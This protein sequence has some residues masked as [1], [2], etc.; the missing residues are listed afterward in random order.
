MLTCSDV[1]LV[2]DGTEI[3]AHRCILTARSAYFKAMFSSGMKESQEG[4][5]H[6]DAVDLVVFCQ[7]LKFMYTGSCDLDIKTENKDGKESKSKDTE[8][9]LAAQL[10]AAADRFQLT[11]LA[12]LCSDRLGETI[13]TSNALDLLVI[14]DNTNAVL[15]KVCMVGVRELSHCAFAA[16]RDGVLRAGQQA[17]LGC[18]GQASSR[19]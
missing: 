14:A 7:L 16:T 9:V 19:G 10:L 8:Q 17:S 1:K 5:V 6:I 13:T 15:L 11:D 3:A 12:V 4:V 18:A 2:I